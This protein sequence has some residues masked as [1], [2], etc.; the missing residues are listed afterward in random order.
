MPGKCQYQ[1]LWIQDGHF[2]DWVLNVDDRKA[3]TKCEEIK[4]LSNKLDY[5]QKILQSV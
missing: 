5:K 3:K 1:E 4:R 2:K